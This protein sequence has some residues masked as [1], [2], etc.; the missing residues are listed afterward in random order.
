MDGRTHALT[1]TRTDARTDGQRENSI[2]PTNKV[3][4]GYNYPVG[5]ELT[6]YL[7]ETRFNAFANKADQD[8]AALARVYSICLWKYDLSDPTLVDLTS[9]FFVL[10]TNM[11]VYL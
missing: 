7:N 11:K 6:L 9:N 5:K 8:Q 2:P 10:C 1:D 4:G 3:C